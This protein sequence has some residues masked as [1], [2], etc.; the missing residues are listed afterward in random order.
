LGERLMPRSQDE[1]YEEK[2]TGIRC[3]HG[4]GRDLPR[5]NG[6]RLSC[7]RLNRRRKSSG[8]RPVPARARHNGFL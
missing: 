1:E 7:G 8:R 5:P 4:S 2:G 6:S 3:A